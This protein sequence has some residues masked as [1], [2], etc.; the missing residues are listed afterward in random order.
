MAKSGGRQN[1]TKK[2]EGST[3]WNP[4]RKVVPVLHKD[5]SVPRRLT[6]GFDGVAS[7]AWRWTWPQPLE[8]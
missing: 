1:K 3:A 5:G 4:Q 2:P 6:G 8:Q 7:A